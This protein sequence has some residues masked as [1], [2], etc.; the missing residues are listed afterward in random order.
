[1]RRALP[2]AGGQARISF[3][4]VAMSMWLDTKQEMTV[5]YAHQIAD[6]FLFGEP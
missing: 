5:N 3:R 2:G 1:M 4:R 6:R